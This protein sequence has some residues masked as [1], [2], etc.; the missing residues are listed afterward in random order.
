[1]FQVDG[2]PNVR[3]DVTLLRDG[4]RVTAVNT[5]GGLEHDRARILNRFASLPAG[6]LLLQGVSFEALV[7]AL[8]THV[9]R[10]HR[11]WER[12]GSMPRAA[13]RPSAMDF[14]TSW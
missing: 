1:M 4:M 12:W 2:S 14:A 10:D 9:P 5:F 3:G 6:R 7:S 8:G 13:R 11:A